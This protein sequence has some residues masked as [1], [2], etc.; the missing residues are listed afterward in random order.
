MAAR[1]VAGNSDVSGP[2]GTPVLDRGQH[3][4]FAVPDAFAQWAHVPSRLVFEGTDRRMPRLTIAIPTYRRGELLIEAV[5][6]AIN[7]S[8]TE[9]FEVIVVDNDPDSEGAAPLLAALPQLAEANF[10]YYVNAENTGMFGNW[11]RSIE[12]ARADWYTMLHD[13]DLFEPEFAQQMMAVL[14]RDRSIDGLTC[15]RLFFGSKA[16][17]TPPSPIKVAAHRIHAELLFRGRRAR[18]FGLRRLFWWATNPVGLIVRK[19]DCLA[20]G[21]YQ[22]GEWPSSDYYFQLRF[23]IRHRLYELRDHLVRIRSEE[24]ESLKPETAMRILV[25]AHVLR[26]R[27]AGTLVPRWWG[28]LSKMVLERY[29]PTYGFTREAVEEAAG[30]KLPRDRRALFAV[31]KGM[32]GGY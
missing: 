9:P 19:Q 18:P 17:T 8:W 12:L 6:S 4:W 30:F 26:T 25:D 20:L 32:T 23:A 5:A 3:D 14:S 29:R 27:M 10:R 21:G 31:L 15:Q 13:D 22:P 11:N 28:R 16:S 24:N 7:Q 2:G 1:F